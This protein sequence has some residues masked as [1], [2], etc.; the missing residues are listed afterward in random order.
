MIE[1]WSRPK[2]TWV[3]RL[4]WKKCVWSEREWEKWDLIHTLT[5]YRKRSSMDWSFCQGSVEPIEQTESKE[6]WLDG[7]KKLSRFYWEETQK[8]WWTEKLLRSYW[9][10][11]EQINFLRW[12]YREVVELEEKEFIK[13]GNHIKMNATSK[14]LNQRSKQHIKL[15][16]HL[17]TKMQSIHRSKTH[18]H[19]HTHTHN[20]SNQFYISKTS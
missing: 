17:S 8:S 13:G 20:N 16:K 11:K 9:V 3:E 7:L 19:T 6:F 5:I 10:D 14:L 18:T 12:I 4:E 15:S 1:A 2:I